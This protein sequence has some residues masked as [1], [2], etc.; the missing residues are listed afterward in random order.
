M[1]FLDEATSSLDHTSEKLTQATIDRQ[2]TQSKRGMI[3]VSIA[4]RLSIIRGCV[5]LN[6]LS[7]AM[8]IVS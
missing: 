4:H 5:T 1:L 2:G 3:V 7:S 6:V 8:L